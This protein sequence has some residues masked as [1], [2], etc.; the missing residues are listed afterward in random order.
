MAYQIRKVKYCYLMVPSRSGQ[1][2][3]VLHELKLAGVNLLAFS[4]FP[5]RA[6]KS[7]LDLIADNMAGIARVARKNNWHLSKVKQCFLAQGTDEAGAVEKV[8]KRLTE[9]N[10]NIIAADAVAAGKG[11]YG[12][13]FWVKPDKFTQA[14]RV[15]NA[16]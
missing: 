15:L 11:R 7:Q 6:G 5:A 13:I 9:V 8:L 1:A 12:M 2:A 10:I 4:G 3:K 14:A 16:R